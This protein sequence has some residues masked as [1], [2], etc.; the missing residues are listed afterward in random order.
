MLTTPPSQEARVAI[1]P[2]FAWDGQDAYLFDIDGTLLRSRDRIHFNSFAASVQ[3][4]TGFEITL[5]GILLHG[6]T[7]TAILREA[8]QQ[9][10]IPAEVMEQRM[11]TILEAMRHAVAEQRQEMELI[12]M[13]GVEQVLDHLARKGA[14]LGVASGNLEAIGWIK[15]EQAGL[16]EW[17]RFGGF[18]DHFSVRPELIGQAA[19]KAREMAGKGVG[20]C[21]VGDTPRDIEAA[22][23]NFLSVIAVATGN[24]SFDEL[25]RLQPEVCA[26]SLADL[27]ALTRTTP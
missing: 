3:R 22:R 14:L 10:G 26:S 15:I 6:A 2:G 8:C 27:L 4:V 16:R 9:A 13:P 17:F 1:E 12:R 24:Y 23:A 5:A 25:H 11:E 18:S 21:I 19:L 7:D 20:I